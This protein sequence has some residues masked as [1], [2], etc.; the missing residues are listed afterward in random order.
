MTKLVLFG[1]KGGVGK[2]TCAAATAIHAARSGYRTLIVS[3]DPAHSTGDI[4]GQEIGNEPTPIRGEENLHALEI[5][6]EE[7]IRDMMP[8]I[9][10]V[11]DSAQ[12]LFGGIGGDNLNMNQSDLLMPGLDEAL[13]F[14]RLL[15]HVESTEF[16]TIIFDTA[17]TGHTMRFLSLPHLLDGWLAK[18]LRFRIQIGRIKSLIR[19]ERDSTT[20]EIERL[21]KRIQHIERVL[22][23][24]ALTSFNAVLIPEEMA[25]AETRRAL[26]FLENTGV[27]VRNLVVNHVFPERSVCE[28][29]SA[30]RAVQNPYLLRI[31]QEF[32]GYNVVTLP[33]MPIEIRGMEALEEIAALL[34]G[35]ERELDITFRKSHTIEPYPGGWHVRVFL[36][37]AELDDIVL[38]AEGSVLMIDI[39]GVT[40]RLQMPADIEKRNIKAKY[41]NDI[42]YVEIS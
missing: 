34:F 9:R 33:E 40:N 21:K 32:P 1:G 17:P 23:N 26:T 14:D 27:P 36:P 6:P 28:L 7:C 2:T 35:G 31:P 18:L 5:D 24:P 20:R 25:L 15:N 38:E 39:N 29:C 8:K 13:A 3:S 19:G 16:D 11:L 37:S 4:F 12:R 22:T 10:D 41:E 42:L 30:R